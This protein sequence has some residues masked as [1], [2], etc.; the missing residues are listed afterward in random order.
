[1]S[2]RTVTFRLPEETLL[3][4]DSVA[5]VQDRDRTYL[6]N[7]AISQYLSLH[8]YHREMIEAGLHQD[9]AGDLLDHEEIQKLTKGWTLAVDAH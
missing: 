3:A 9:E 5:E 6:L 2:L 4:L 1:M 8:A 7:E